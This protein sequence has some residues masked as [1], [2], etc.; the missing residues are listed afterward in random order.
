VN[1]ER[2]ARKADNWDGSPEDVGAP[3]SQ[4]AMGFY[5]L[6]EGQLYLLYVRRQLPL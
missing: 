1:A 5:G 4:K 6:L 2:P 3:T